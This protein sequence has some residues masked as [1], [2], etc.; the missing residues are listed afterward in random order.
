MVSVYN[1]DIQ[2]PVYG[3]LCLSYACLSIHLFICHSSYFVCPRVCP[4]M[5]A[6]VLPSLE[7]YQSGQTV[8]YTCT[9]STTISQLC[10]HLEI[11]WLFLLPRNNPSCFQYASVFHMQSY[12]PATIEAQS[13]LMGG[14]MEYT[15]VG[16]STL[17]RDTVHIEC[18]AF[19]VTFLP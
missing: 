2:L 5:I 14:N 18:L 3:C 12:S 9:I 6:T 17:H 11:V 15:C 4:F 19:N 10:Q 16:K 7:N 8:L 13:G 1:T